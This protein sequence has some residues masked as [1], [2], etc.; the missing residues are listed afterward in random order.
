MLNAFAAHIARGEPLV[1]DGREGINGLM[2]SNAI[3]LSGWT[4]ETVTIPF[5]ENKFLSLLRER[6]A[7]SRHKEETDILIDPSGDYGSVPTL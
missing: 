4:G 3:H 7:T 6:S 1:A 5:D 2:L